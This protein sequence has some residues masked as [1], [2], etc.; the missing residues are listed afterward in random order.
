MKT[1]ITICINLALGLGIIAQDLP[2][3]LKDYSPMPLPTYNERETLPKPDD[4]WFI[5]FSLNGVDTI[6]SNLTDYPD[7]FWTNKNQDNNSLNVI[8]ESGSNTLNADEP[9]AYLFSN[10]QPADGIPGFPYYPFSAVVKIYLA[11]KDDNGNISFSSCSGIMIGPNHVLT[12]GHCIKSDD[13]VLVIHN[14]SVA[15]PAYNMGTSP[16]GYAYI[17][18]WYAFNGWL[19]G[20][21][22]N[23]DVGV[24]SLNSSIGKTTGYHG[25]AYNLNNG[26][27]TNST[28]SLSSIGYPAQDDNGN[29]VYEAGERMYAMNGSMDFIKGTNILCHNNIGFRGQSGSGLYFKDTNGDRYALGV[30]SHGNGKTFPY[31]TCHTRMD[32]QMF[33]QIVGIVSSSID[34]TEIQPDKDQ[35]FEIY[36][37]PVVDEL[38]VKTL[39][40]NV[41]FE[42]KILD[43]MG[44]VLIHETVYH[45]T[46]PDV[47]KFDLSKLG[48]G[49]YVCQLNTASNL[50][51]QKLILKL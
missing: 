40:S 26:W 42:L 31:N 9:N 16:Y 36:P 12:A 30:L 41:Y 1:Y 25:L 32:A 51:T 22:F 37:N 5:H 19:Q 15:V 24:L 2:I 39:G 4:H 38:S 43:I 46:D 10:L 35:R 33:N 45:T 18:G 49:T 48:N 44:K 14:G 28:Q 50:L 29:P 20:Q 11:M 6:K 7:T 8:D 27:F 21:D 23:Y 13:K 17:N 34:I 3:N 47:Y